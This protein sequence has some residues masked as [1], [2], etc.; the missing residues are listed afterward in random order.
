MN[1]ENYNSSNG[2]NQYNDNNQNSGAINDN[3]YNGYGNANGGEYYD[4]YASDSSNYGEYSDEQQYSEQNYNGYDNYGNYYSD[5]G[6]GNPQYEQHIGMAEKEKKKG[7]MVA[8]IS[9]LSVVIVVGVTV[10]ILFATGVIG[11]SKEEKFADMVM[12]SFGSINDEAKK[13]EKDTQKLLKDMEKDDEDADDDIDKDD[14]ADSKKETGEIRYITN[15]DESAYFRSEPKDSNDNIIATID[16]GKKVVFLK[17]INNKFAKIKYDG[18]TGYIER[19]NLTSSKPAA[20]K[21]EQAPTVDNSVKK[22]MYVANVKN[23]IYLRS[24][25]YENQSNIIFTIPLG[26]QV[27]YIETANG[28]F[29]KIIYNGTV[30]YAKTCYLSDS[31]PY[32]NQTNTYMTVCNVKYAIYLRSQP[33]ENPN[34]IICE[35]PLGSTVEFLEN[36]NGTFYKINWNGNVGYAKSMYL[37]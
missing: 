12:D 34:N 20:Q 6:Y 30:G 7:V 25:P 32:Y 33:K 16:Y 37:R 3:Q 13:A 21:K 14:D 1:D 26:E 17:N 10:A 19:E 27:G 9:V 31:Q 29:S 23:S 28:S 5:G 36:T 22:Y 35:I 8:V 4:Q 15:C 24:E 11:K 18:E 2:G